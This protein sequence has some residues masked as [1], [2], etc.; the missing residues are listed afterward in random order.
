[1][2]FDLRGLSL[3]NGCYDLRLAIL[4]LMQELYPCMEGIDCRKKTN[5]LIQKRKG[6]F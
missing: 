5:Y 2:F 6:H 4:L 3:P 1:M